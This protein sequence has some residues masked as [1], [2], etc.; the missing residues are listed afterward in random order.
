MTCRLFGVQPLCKPMLVYCQLNPW[1][2]TSVKSSVKSKH[3]TFHS[4]KCIWKYPLLNCNHFVQRVVSKESIII[5]TIMCNYS[6]DLIQVSVFFSILFTGVLALVNT[7]WIVTLLT[8]LQ[9]I[10]SLFVF[11]SCI[12]WLFLVIRRCLSYSF[13]LQCGHIYLALPG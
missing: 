3:K 8:I 6:V 9:I 10:S 1:E 5:T 12:I 11:S 2:Q 4:R 13:K 7:V